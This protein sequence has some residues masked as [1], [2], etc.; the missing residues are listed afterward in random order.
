MTETNSR[1][2]N[3]TVIDLESERKRETVSLRINEELNQCIETEAERR[4]VGKSTVIRDA[5][6]Q[7]FSSSTNH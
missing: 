6:Q 4:G 5:C 2:R 1:E 3:C 7:L